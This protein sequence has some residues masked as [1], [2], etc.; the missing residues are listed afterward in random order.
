MTECDVA[1]EADCA[2]VEAETAVARVLGND[3][4]LA[5]IIWHAAA[6]IIPS[7]SLG[8]VL[9]LTRLFRRAALQDPRVWRRIHLPAPWDDLAAGCTQSCFLALAAHEGTLL[10][11]KLV[12]GQRIEAL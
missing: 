12:E 9:R 5:E 7:A 2:V 10:I 4:L 1:A 3:S 8:A 6:P 11:A